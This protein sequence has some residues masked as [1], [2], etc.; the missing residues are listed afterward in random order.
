MLG[1]GQKKYD[2]E[3]DNEAHELAACSVSFI[4]V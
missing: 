2:H 4:E 1:D 3:R